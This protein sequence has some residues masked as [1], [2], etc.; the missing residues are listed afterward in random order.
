MRPL[1]D[2]HRRMLPTYILAVLF[3][4]QI[5]ARAA[6]FWLSTSDDVGAGSLP[7]T[8]SS[9]IP[10]V[11]QGMNSSGSFFIWAR[12]DQGKSLPLLNWSLNVVSSNPN[13]L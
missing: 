4:C 5:P 11:D 3:A 8:D 13:A 6:N 10:V 12:P 7:P 9:E 1:G 2:S